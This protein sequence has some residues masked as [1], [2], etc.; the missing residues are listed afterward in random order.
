[1]TTVA[2]IVVASPV[3]PWAA[4]GLHI[5]DGVAH[6]GGIALR[7]ESVQTDSVIAITAWT[8]HGAPSPVV[9]IDGLLTH[10]IDEVVAIDG[11]H[12]LGVVSFDHVV[13]MTSSLERTS[14]AIEALTGAELKRVREAGPVR[15]GFHRLGAIIVEVVESESVTSELA[16]FWGFVLV[17]DDIHEAAGRLGPDL[18]SPPKPAVQT[19][20]YIASFRP[21]AGLG[22]PVALM[23]R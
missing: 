13:V 23:S 14:G 17:V 2:E 18:L 20:R 9:S 19:G 4:L 8:L 16:S 6:I 11:E 5:S 15:Q 12:P 22:F 10:H 7:F 1:V 21:A 3:E